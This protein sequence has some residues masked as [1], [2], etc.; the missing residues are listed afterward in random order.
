MEVR[1][2]KLQLELQNF[3]DSEDGS[4]S[5]LVYFLFLILLFSSLLVL[6]ISDSYLAKRQLTQIG[7][8]AASLATHQIDYESYYK[9]GLVDHGY[10]FSQVP[11]DCNSALES[12][13]K[14]LISNSLR[15]SEISLD[16]YQCSNEKVALDISAHIKPL[17]S[18]PSVESRFQIKA[19]VIATA[20][21]G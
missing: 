3:I 1:I 4:I 11:I 6:D 20:V 12:A 5:I 19:K 10:G 16:E 9:N 2:N 13:R 14:Y 18:L 7:N 15:G 8:A 21:V 17:I